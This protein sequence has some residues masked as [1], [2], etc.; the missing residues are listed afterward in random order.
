MDLPDKFPDFLVSAGFFRMLSHFRFHPPDSSGYAS[1]FFIRR[2]LP[3]TPPFLLSS[4]GFFRTR[5]HFFLV[6]TAL[7]T[8]LTRL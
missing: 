8:F 2:I 3:A 1:I 5:I 7:D 6:R 4:A